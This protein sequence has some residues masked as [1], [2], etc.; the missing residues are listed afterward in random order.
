MSK[1]DIPLESMAVGTPQTPRQR[2]A[3]EDWVVSCLA[4]LPIEVV[5]YASA[6]AHSI[7]GDSLTRYRNNNWDWSESPEEIK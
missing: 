1:L 4:A 7:S 6:S 5:I 2:M 3:E